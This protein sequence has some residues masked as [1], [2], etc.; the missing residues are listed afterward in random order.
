MKE[1]LKNEG[2]GAMYSES[3]NVHKKKKM[4]SESKEMCSSYSVQLNGE[5]NGYAE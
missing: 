3:K 4:Y 1:R 2:E 5:W